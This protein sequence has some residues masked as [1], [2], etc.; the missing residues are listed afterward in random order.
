MMTAVPI[1]IAGICKYR[2]EALLM[3]VTLSNGLTLDICLDSSSG[4][5]DVNL[6]GLR[7]EARD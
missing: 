1:R 5:G 3:V 6:A 4:H 7:M 2:L